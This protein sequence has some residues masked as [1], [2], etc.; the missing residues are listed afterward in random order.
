MINEDKGKN[1][2]GKVGRKKSMPCRA[3]YTVIRCWVLFT[4]L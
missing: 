3:L 4:E 2:V 1:E